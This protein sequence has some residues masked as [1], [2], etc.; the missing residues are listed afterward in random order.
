[1]IHLILRSYLPNSGDYHRNRN[2]NPPHSMSSWRTRLLDEVGFGGE[3]L[4]IREEDSV[5]V[6]EPG[7]GSVMS[8]LKPGQ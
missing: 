4:S 1:M 2:G 8:I 3:G 6:F 5:R 7:R